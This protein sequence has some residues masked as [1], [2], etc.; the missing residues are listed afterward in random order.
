MKSI[1]VPAVVACLVSLVAC[2]K[3]APP[4]PPPAAAPAAPAAS[5]ALLS[6][7]TA[8]LNAAGPDSFVVTF[9]TS[10]GAFD[11]M[12]HRAWSPRGAD[13][14]HYLASNGFFEG[15][16]FYRVISGFMAQFGA[17]GVPAVDAAWNNLR[18]LDDAVKHSNTRGTLTFATSGPNSR[19]TQLFINFGNNANLDG[20]GFSP[21]GQVKG[22]GMKVVDSLFAGYGEGAPGG[23]GPDQG[24]I[25]S[26]GNAY[27]AR[28][29][30]KLDSIV[31]AKVG[32]EWKKP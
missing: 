15:V 17:K 4:P 28:D 14:V 21:L 20:M 1:H 25:G 11:V 5:A 27:L 22:N 8:K 12:V 29:F 19:T 13:R 32:A 30:S 2:E 9:T 10:K 3:S 7:D 18:L 6:P 16:R 31:T 24:R 26:E 23:Q